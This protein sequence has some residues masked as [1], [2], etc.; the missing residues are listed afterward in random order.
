MDATAA[1]IY[2]AEAEVF[3]AAVALALSYVTMQASD[4]YLKAHRTDPVV[5]SELRNE[6]LDPSIHR[7]GYWLF[8]ALYFNIIYLTVNLTLV[9]RTLFN[10]PYIYAAALA[11]FLLATYLAL[12][13]VFRF[14]DRRFAITGI[15]FSVLGTVVVTATIQLGFGHWTAYGSSATSASTGYT[16]AG[17]AQQMVIP[18]VLAAVAW[19]ITLVSFLLDSG[20]LA[21]HLPFRF[22]KTGGYK[23]LLAALVMGWAGVML[24]VLYPFYRLL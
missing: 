5:E 12:L 23:T 17:Q 19:V 6:N 8:F 16:L 15:A 22:E 10:S 3:P 24:S 21:E 13:F 9:E 11:A 20:T 7:L 18:I 4:R 14:N 2:L 1:L